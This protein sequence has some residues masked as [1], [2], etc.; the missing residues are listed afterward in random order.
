MRRREFISGLTSVAA[1]AW[2]PTALAQQ[3]GRVRRIAMLS[4]GDETDRV[5]QAQQ[6]AMREALAKLGWIES[7]NVRFELRYSADDAARMYTHA[8]ELVHLAP[9]V[10]AVNAVPATVAVLQR[11]RTIPIVFVNVGDPVA[12]GLLKNIAR[13]EGNATGITSLFQSLA[14]KWLEL[15][16]EAAPRTA[17]VALIFVPGIVVE[18][19]FAAIEPAAE[20]LG[21]T[22]V[23]MPYRSASE[24]ERAIDSFS[25]EPNGGLVIVPPPPF[26]SNRKLL[27]RIAVK[28]RLPTIY[29]SK[30]HGP[31]EGGLMSYG[32]DGIEAN[33]LAASYVDRIL[34]GTKI[35]ELPVQF[36]TKFELVINLKTAKAIGLSIPESL[37]FRADEVIE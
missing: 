34:R 36:P 37:L 23:R 31:G 28:Y 16:K 12:G 2:P 22:A 33:R 20:V 13:P 24:L 32:S 25:T 27:N 26:S 7:R 17:R 18:N 19:Y 21:I 1:V 3:D 15:L 6:G 4:R 30:E 8:D 35:S 11:T 14:G 5:V 29:P 9:D 10:I